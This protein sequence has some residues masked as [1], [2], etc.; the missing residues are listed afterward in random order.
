MYLIEK[1]RSTKS[2]TV[3]ILN[4]PTHATFKQKR[5]VSLFHL[6]IKILP[7]AELLCKIKVGTGAS[8]SIYSK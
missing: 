8:I 3:S 5:K 2:A 1:F 4:N 7:L 6:I